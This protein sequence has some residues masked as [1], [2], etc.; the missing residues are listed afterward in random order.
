MDFSDTHM[1]LTRFKAGL[2][3]DAVSVDPTTSDSRIVPTFNAY[4]PSG[5]VTAEVVYVNYGGIED[6]RALEAL[7]VTV[8]GKIVIAR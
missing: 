8:Q 1:L 5:D 6:Y 2:Q 7:G 4:S 3:E